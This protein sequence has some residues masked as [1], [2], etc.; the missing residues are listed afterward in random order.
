MPSFDAHGV[1]R[2]EHQGAGNSVGVFPAEQ[3]RQDKCGAEKNVFR[4]K[5][6]GWRV[7]GKLDAFPGCSGIVRRFPFVQIYGNLP[8]S[9]RVGKENRGGFYRG[10]G[11]FFGL[12]LF[13]EEKMGGK[14][15]G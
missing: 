2:N 3:A 15:L 5:A 4:H 14:E 9:N 8:E 11:R 10:A 1:A 13:W 12:S 6:E 7:T